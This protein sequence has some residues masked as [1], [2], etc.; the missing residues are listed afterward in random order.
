MEYMIYVKKYMIYA[1]GK[2]TYAKELNEL[3]ELKDEEFPVIK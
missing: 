3:K 1:M 2:G